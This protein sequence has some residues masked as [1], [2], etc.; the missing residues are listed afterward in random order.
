[1]YHDVIEGDDWDVSGF[2]GDA[3]GSYKLSRARFEEHLHAI[4]S[5]AG[6][7]RIGALGERD[8]RDDRREVL[9]TFDDGGA[10]AL[11]VVSPLLLQEGWRAY[12]FIATECIGQPSFLGRHDIVTLHEQGHVIGTHSCSHPA[13]IDRLPMSAL[14]D[15]WR[16][17]R[18]CL[19]GLLKV[20]V[21]AA[22]VPGGHF[23]PR[24]AEAAA[25]AGVEV[26]FTSEPTI[27]HFR[28]SQCLVVGRYTL[29]N[30]TPGSVAANLVLD[31]VAARWRQAAC[32]RFKR[33]LQRMSGPAYR[34][35]RSRI[36]ARG[37][38]IGR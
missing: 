17:S 22:S 9:L 36:L 32:W 6:S 7:R 12:F 37:H 30:S 18:E 11:S 13:R 1:M 26:L 35:L 10:S 19:S 24:V 27:R 33:T 8:R 14:V 3:A 20:D 5:A 15:E 23:H 34:A 31:R 38:G 25:L 2:P 4:R 28:I 29:R 21:R 16:R